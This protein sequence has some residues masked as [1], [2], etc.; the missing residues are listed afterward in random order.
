M[1]GRKRV[2][3]TGGTGNWGRCV[4]REFADRADRIEVTALVLDTPA[5]RARISEFAGMPNLRV[6]FGM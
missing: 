1:V 2:F 3:L 5:E 6:V 4:L